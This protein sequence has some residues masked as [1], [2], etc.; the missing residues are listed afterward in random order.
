[1]FYREECVEQ[2]SIIFISEVFEK[3]LYGSILVSPTEPI[4]LID[5]HLLN[6]HKVKYNIQYFL[7]FK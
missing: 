4:T 2:F 3:A 7:V 6:S 1:V 5:L